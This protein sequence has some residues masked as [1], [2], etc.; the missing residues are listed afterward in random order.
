MI[1]N[2]RKIEIFTV[3]GESIIKV[4]LLLLIRFYLIFGVVLSGGANRSSLKCKSVIRKLVASLFLHAQF[5]LLHFS[6][7]HTNKSEHVCRAENEN[8]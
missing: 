5:L 2:S 8:R 7:L 4:F 3:I 6:M 1:E